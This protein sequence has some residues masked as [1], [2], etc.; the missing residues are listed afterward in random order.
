MI[1]P[2]P[3]GS[4]VVGARH[5]VLADLQPDGT[6]FTEPLAPAVVGLHE[7]ADGESP[8]RRDAVPMPPLKSWQ[9]IP[10]PPPT[11]PSATGPPAAAR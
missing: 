1:E 9:T 2:L 10:V 4:D 5:D 6:P 3:G 11:E 7:H 8:A